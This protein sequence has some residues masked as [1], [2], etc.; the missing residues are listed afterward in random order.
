[1]AYGVLRGSTRLLVAGGGGASSDTPGS[2][3]PGGGAGGSGYAPGGTTTAG[4]GTTP[5]NASDIDYAAPAGVGSTSGQP[6]S[7]GRAVATWSVTTPTT[8]DGPP[9]AE[10]IETVLRDRMGYRVVRADDS[11]LTSITADAA[12]RT[13]TAAGGSFLALGLAPGDVVSWRN[14]SAPAN[15]DVLFTAT[16]V[17]ASDL[18]VR[19]PVADIAMADTDFE[20]RFGEVDGAALDALGALQPAPSGWKVDGQTGRQAMDVLLTTVGGWMDVLP[21]GLLTF[22]RLS[23]PA[24]IGDWAFGPG[25]PDGGVIG[26]PRRLAT[27]PAQWRRRLGARRCWRQ[28]G[29]TEIGAFPGV[30]AARRGFLRHETR[31]EPA[32]DQSVRV[33]DLLA[34]GDAD[35][36]T[37]FD[38]IEDAKVEAARQLALFSP[39]R[40][41]WEVDLPIAAFLV[42]NGQTVELHAP[43]NGIEQPTRFVVLEI[44]RRSA[45]RRVT[46]V[47]WG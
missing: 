47:V 41:A 39:D 11:V 29:P 13:F 36:P 42:R 46:L 28:H 4:I 43:G 25:K 37:A 8:T 26:E 35:L 38:R 15:N 27:A 14:L 3:S 9:A 21:E 18:T 30:S 20:L 44:E 2:N 19:E 7:P 32:E 1:N 10:L 45:E 17:T 5:G 23:S 6:G 16:A 12:T 33:K 24:A 31:G 34:K 40:T 22:G